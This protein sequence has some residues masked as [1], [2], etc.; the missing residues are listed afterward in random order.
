[1]ST[2]PI[3]DSS[4]QQHPAHDGR[5]AATTLLPRLARFS[6][7]RRL[8]VAFVVSAL[9]V[10]GGTAAPRAAASAADAS[11]EPGWAWPLQPAPVVVRGFDPPAQP[12]L[13]G[14]RGVDLAGSAGQPVL[15]PATGRIRFATEL[16]G[17]GVVVVETDGL[18]LTFEPVDAVVRPGDRVTA[19]TVLGHLQ[20]VQS[21]CLP[22]ACLHWGVKRGDVYLDPL[23]MV[24]DPE[25]VLLP[26]GDRLPGAAPAIHHAPSS[27][28]RARLSSPTDLFWVTRLAMRVHDLVAIR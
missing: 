27:A 4:A 24:T 22:A 2:D 9:V 8:L 15:A 21:H 3:W 28:A 13:P 12:W 20:L 7:A 10:C 11:S 1:M 19:G 14:H 6:V 25:I 16:A 18:R 5:M 17:R 23:A 26:L